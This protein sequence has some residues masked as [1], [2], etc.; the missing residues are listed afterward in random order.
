[1]LGLEQSQLWVF[2][3]SS[4]YIFSHEVIQ[5]SNSRVM[6]KF[7]HAIT[8]LRSSKMFIK[9]LILASVILPLCVVLSTSL[10]GVSLWFDPARDLLSAWDNLSKLTLLGPPSGIQGIFYGPYWIWLLSLGLLVSKDPVVV[11]FITATLPYFIIF[12]FIWFKFSKY[13]GL[14][15]TLI[16]WFIFV[17]SFASTYATHL[18]NP[19]PAPLLTLAALYL[20]I[21]FDNKNITIKNTF[22]LLAIGLLLGLVINFHLSFGIALIAGVYLFLIWETVSLWFP[23]KNLKLLPAKL[24]AFVAIGIG[25]LISFLPTLLFEI[26]H[27]FNQLQTFLHTFTQYGDVVQREGMPAGEIL[28]VFISVFGNLMHVSSFYAGLLLSFLTIYFLIQLK[29]KE[30]QLQATDKKILALVVAILIAISI[31]YFSA[32]NPIWNYHFIGAEIVFLILLTFFVAKLPFVR[33]IIFIWLLSFTFLGTYTFFKTPQDTK[34]FSN[35]K[36]V[37]TMIAQDAGDKPYT[38]FSYSYA[39]YNYEYT[40]LFKW[41]AHKDLPVDPALIPDAPFVYIIVPT[42]QTPEMEDFISNHSKAATHLRTW[43]MPG[44][45]T[46]IKLKRNAPSEN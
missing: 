7:Q 28:K 22:V 21:R 14:K 42:K 5:L 27:G 17:F 36:D 6:K 1:M 30:V 31:L 41:L 39:I 8:K 23:K 40:Y 38:V 11:T 29:R 16:G 32:K 26:R 20:L 10:L 43:K 3:L 35:Q 34:F 18:W 33:M 4:L 9:L 25:A 24:S 44:G 46:V 37:V 19:Y 45:I 12:P 2:I 15:A 13:F